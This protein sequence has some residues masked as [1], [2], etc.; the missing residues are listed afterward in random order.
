[1]LHP[2]V[3]RLTPIARTG[4][5]ITVMP[6][7]LATTAHG[8]GRDWDLFGVVGAKGDDGEQQT[9]AV[10]LAVKATKREIR[11][12]LETAEGRYVMVEGVYGA[13]EHS[14][15]GLDVFRRIHCKAKDV[16]VLGG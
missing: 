1:M 12:L 4:L 14:E 9:Y 13:L 16:K 15:D 5:R 8:N 6:V 11:D 7:R 10:S 3:S 2:D